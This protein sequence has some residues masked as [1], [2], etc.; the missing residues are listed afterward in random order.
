MREPGGGMREPIGVK[1]I[2]LLQATKLFEWVESA[3]DIADRKGLSMIYVGGV[4]VC[5]CEGK[6]ETEMVPVSAILKMTTLTPHEEV[7]DSFRP[8]G[9]GRP[10]KVKAGG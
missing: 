7:L 3:Y 9:P 10:P 8:R 6:E 1:Q 5:V 2:R 4:V